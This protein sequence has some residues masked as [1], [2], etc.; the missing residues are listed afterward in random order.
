MDDDVCVLDER[1][2]ERGVTNIPVP[3][4]QPAVRRRLTETDR[5][6][7]DAACIREKVEHA[8]LIVRILV[9]QVP[10]EI[11][12]DETGAAGDEKRLH[13]VIPERDSAPPSRIARAS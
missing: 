13:D 6:V 5:Q 7:L 12:A 9:V 11:A 8:D 2:D 10:Y 3:E 1:I 4:L